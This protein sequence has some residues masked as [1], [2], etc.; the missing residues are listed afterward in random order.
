MLM[1]KRYVYDGN[2]ALDAVP[3]GARIVDG[4]LSILPEAI[5]EDSGIPADRRTD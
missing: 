1:Y 3:V 2:I 5:Q 4:K